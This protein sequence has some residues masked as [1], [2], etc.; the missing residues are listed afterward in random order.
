M[1]NK[2]VMVCLDNFVLISGKSERLQAERF[3]TF[4]EEI[5]QH[6]SLQ[7]LNN[8]VK[9]VENRGKNL[10]EKYLHKK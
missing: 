7:L 3:L 6:K 2:R 8:R 5:K 10:S 4:Q 1:C 9:V